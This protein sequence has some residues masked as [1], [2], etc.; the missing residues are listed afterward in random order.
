MWA[1][2]FADISLRAIGKRAHTLH[3]MNYF[4]FFSGTISL[5]LWVTK[6]PVY[7]SRIEAYWYRIKWSVIIR[8]TDIETPADWQAIALLFAVSLFGF[9]AQVRAGNSRKDI[10][11]SLGAPQDNARLGSPQRNGLTWFTC[12][13]YSGKLHQVGSSNLIT[14]FAV[15]RLCLP[16]YLN[17]FFSTRH[18]LFF[19]W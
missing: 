16:T 15:H 7:S 19:L 5:C 14:S 18:L 4:A 10:S 3:C 13:I 12:H 9:G 8:K 1:N 2:G 6:Y 11:S 17:G